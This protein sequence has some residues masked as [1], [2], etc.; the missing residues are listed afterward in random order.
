MSDKV[1]FVQM[2]TGTMAT[3]PSSTTVFHGSWTVLYALADDGTIW[4]WS[5]S[6][7]TQ[8]GPQPEKSAT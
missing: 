5:G 2:V 1:R 8:C 7:W 4:W 6:G 3:A